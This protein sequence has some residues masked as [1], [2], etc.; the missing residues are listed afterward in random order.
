MG[1]GLMGSVSL[2]LQGLRFSLLLL[3]WFWVSRRFL[4]LFRVVGFMD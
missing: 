2:D 3:L 1:L 4:G